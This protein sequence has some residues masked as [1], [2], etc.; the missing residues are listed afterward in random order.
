MT[1]LELF[2]RYGTDKGARHGYAPL[3]ETILDRDRPLRLLEIGV[4]KGASLRAWRAYL[5]PKS[6]IM[7]LDL[8]AE[9]VEGCE[10]Y[11]G[12]QLDVALL[13]QI[14]AR[15]P[16]DVV[17]DDGSHHAHHQQTSYHALWPAVGAG[18]WYVIEDLHVSVLGRYNVVGVTPTLKL[19]LDELHGWALEERRPDSDLELWC[20]AACARRKR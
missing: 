1:I 20:G 13:Q 6:V 11:E 18:G 14:A 10:I 16:L 3:Y 8:S 12:S 5:H 4:H 2:E 19:L 9:P 15:G 7:G 17:I